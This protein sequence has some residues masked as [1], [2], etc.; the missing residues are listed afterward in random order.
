MNKF[1]STVVLLFYCSISSGSDRLFELPREG[2]G[3]VSPNGGS[4]AVV[5]R[6]GDIYGL[7]VIDL[8]TLG[9]VRIFSTDIFDSDFSAVTGFEWIDDHTLILKVVELTEG[10]AKLSDT[11]NK[12]H[13]FI[14]DNIVNPVLRY[15][16]SDGELV[17]ALPHDDGIVLFA[18]A[19]RT[20]VVYRV[21]TS[22]LH[23]WG[24]PRS[25]TERVDG[26]QFSRTTR[27]AEVE[28]VVILW[29]TATSN[30]VSAAFRVNEGGLSL[31][32]RENEADEW[33]VEKDWSPKKRKIRWQWQRE[34]DPVN[35][36]DFYFPLAQIE[37]SNDF[38][39][40]AD[41]EEGNNGVYRYNYAS[42]KKELIYRHPTA[43]FIGVG[44]TQDNT[45]VLYIS[46]FEDGVVKYHYVPGAYQEVLD[47]LTEQYPQYNASI[48]ATDASESTF[49]VFLRSP[50]QP[51]IA[52]LLKKESGEMVQLFATMPWIDESVMAPSSVGKVEHEGL[53]IEYFLTLPNTNK[54]FPLVVYTH[55]GPWGVSDNRQFNPAVQYLAFRG[56]AILQVNYRGSGGYGEDFLR[57]GY[58]A[59]GNQML[60]DIEAA[61]QEV[62]AHPRIDGKRVCVTGESYG[63]YAA[64]MLA[65]RS[66]E[67][68]RCVASFAGVSDLGLLL[69]SY[70][71]GDADLLLKLLLNEDL[72]DD[73][74]YDYLRDISPLYR[75]EELRVPV[76]M[77]HGVEDIR[78]DIEQS[79][80][81]VDRLEQLGKAVTWR[82]LDDQGHSFEKPLD[83]FDYYRS[84]ADFVVMHIYE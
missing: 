2:S 77:Q 39:V 43:E 28:G 73:E 72:T 83:A 33:R 55:G 46:Y 82:Q 45:S 5:V 52:Y 63:G 47:Y 60:G 15:F 9:R 58:G 61:I 34:S 57:E 6:E 31:V 37:G 84:L 62:L 59:F 8:D 27:V 68:F 40:V 24:K 14:V 36:D 66:P 48:A 32:V 16:E 11:R 13:L 29:L 17:D 78:V 26:G 25:K 75:A 71:Q 35:F 65:I 56:M 44:L 64:M 70:E 1:F 74:Q 7:E 80:R 42:E 54:R 20:S 76:L 3:R 49:L 4:L 10:V 19:G 79:L 69:G 53:G 67:L 41:D 30:F 23:V 50:T 22:K 81:M 51:G 18:R 21:D 38:I 12:S